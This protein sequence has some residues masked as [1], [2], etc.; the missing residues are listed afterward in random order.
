MIATKWIAKSKK[1]TTVFL[2]FFVDYSISKSVLISHSMAFANVSH[3]FVGLFEYFVSIFSIYFPVLTK[4]PF[5]PM[6]I[7]PKISSLMSY[8]NTFKKKIKKKL[9]SKEK[10]EEDDNSIQYIHRQSCNIRMVIS[11]LVWHN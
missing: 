2:L 7:A 10:K 8:K 9:S 3:I 5:I 6:F 4:I 11:H 1:L